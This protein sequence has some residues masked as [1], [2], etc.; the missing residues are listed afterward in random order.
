M[1]ILR[2]I[3]I[4]ILV[5]VSVPA[6]ASAQTTTAIPSP[7]SVFGFVPG[8]DRQLMDYGE[9]VDYLLD[10]AAVSDRIEMREVG[11]SPLGR[12]MYVAFISAAENLKR[13]DELREINRRLATD[14]AIPAEERASLV[15]AG[16]VFVM[17]TLS[18]HSGEV[19]P[20]Q[21]L[22]IY[23]HRM[24]TIDDPEI[25]SQL[26]E[27]VLMIMPSHNPDGM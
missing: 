1:K 5:V 13:L 21:S 25:L 19:A 4:L 22:P 3:C 27:V 7:E 2:Q 12:T 16:R 6:I 9:L 10:L 8:T 24:A 11:R 18:M 26:D 20:S 15:S 14:P 23:A 17:Q